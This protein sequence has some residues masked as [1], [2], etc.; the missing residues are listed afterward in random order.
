MH[1]PR[2]ATLIHSLCRKPG[3]LSI[4]IS[5]EASR[6]NL[7]REPPIRSFPSERSIGAFLRPMRLP[8]LPCCLTM[9]LSDTDISAASDVC[10]PS[11]N[12]HP[13]VDRL[14]PFTKCRQ[15]NVPG[16]PCA[17]SGPFADRCYCRTLTAPA[18]CEFL[19]LCYLRFIGLTCYYIELLVAILPPFPSGWQ[20]LSLPLRTPGEKP[21]PFTRQPATG[22]GGVVRSG[23]TLVPCADLA[24]LSS[25]NTLASTEA[26]QGP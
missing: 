26:A 4:G 19:C 20:A 12:T 10:L 18:L 9:L 1:I 17:L 23:A 7:P 22:P 15:G 5:I 6:R 11:Q 13:P 3:V 8:A 24:V 2:G 16:F 21:L 14:L 25:Q